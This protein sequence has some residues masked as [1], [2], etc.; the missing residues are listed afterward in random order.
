MAPPS[1]TVCH[2]LA[3]FERWRLQFFPPLP[4]STTLPCQE[5]LHLNVL[6]LIEYHDGRSFRL[7][8]TIC[9][10]CAGVCN[11]L[12]KQHRHPRRNFWDQQFSKQSLA[13]VAQKALASCNDR[14]RR[15][16]AHQS[17]RHGSA[18][19]AVLTLAPTTSTKSRTPESHPLSTIDLHRPTKH[20]GVG[21]GLIWATTTQ[22]DALTSYMLPSQANLQRVSDAIFERDPSRS[23]ALPATRRTSNDIGSESTVLHPRPPFDRVGYMSSSRDH[24]TGH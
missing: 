21:T 16:S 23:P 8:V 13:L 17:F 19:S 22:R 12:L 3:V 18:R 20:P 7:V 10:G 5:W 9:S 11:G 2:R 1:L 15:S 24:G 14:L 6:I 4:R